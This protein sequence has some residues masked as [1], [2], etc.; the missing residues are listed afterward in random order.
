MG[1]TSTLQDEIAAARDIKIVPTILDTVCRLTGMGFSA[2]ARVTDERWIA[3]AVDDRI[4]FGLKPGGELKLETTICHEIRQ[5]RTGVVI[6][7]VQADPIYCDHH[8]PALYGFRSY[9]SMPII[10]PDGSWFGTLCAIDP[11]PRDLG[12][13][14]IQAT[15]RM[16]ADLLAFHLDAS[17]Q[18]SAS[19]SRLADEVATGELREQ[20]IAVVGHDL[21]N[22]LASIDAGLAMLGK[23]LE[24]R[25]ATAILGQ[26]QSSVR[27]MSSLIDNILDF[28]RGRLGGG[29]SLTA[30]DVEIKPLIRQI[31]TELAASHSDR[32][33]THHCGSGGAVVRCDPQRIGQLLSNLLGNAITHG[34]DAA[35]IVVSCAATDQTFSLTVTNRGAEIPR[36]A[37][38]RLFHP[39]ARGAETVGREGLGLGLYIASEIAKAHSGTLTVASSAEETSFTFSMPIGTGP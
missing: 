13:P 3:C 18:L 21:R 10:R 7:D 27:R 26:M 17:D 16:F 19:E 6:S 25:R 37:R 35:P 33:I 30:A 2:L 31:V 23:T 20:F 36:A 15:F 28:A 39:F 14:E 11:E 12:R 5:A 9:I 22:P 4:D 8:T 24:P 32:Q 29:I 1:M 34:A 38:A